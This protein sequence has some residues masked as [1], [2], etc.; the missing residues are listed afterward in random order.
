MEY[1][2]DN[3]RLSPNLSQSSMIIIVLVS[4]KIEVPINHQQYQ[5]VD[6]ITTILIIY[7]N[8]QLVCLGIAK[9][10]FAD[11]SVLRMTVTQRQQQL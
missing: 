9:N 7:F 5:S 10:V 1:K 6:R 11:I 8:I 2:E 4:K 3:N